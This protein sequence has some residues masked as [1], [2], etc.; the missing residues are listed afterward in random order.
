[1]RRWRRHRALAAAALTGAALLLNGCAQSVDPIE[2]LGE[3]AAQRVR[4]PA[5][6]RDQAY[7][8]WGLRTPLAPAP[9]PPARV[10]LRRR[11]PRRRGASLPPVVDRVPTPDKVV[12]LIYDDTAEKAPRFVDMVRELR[13]PVTAF[14]ADSAFRPRVVWHDTPTYTRGP[15]HL[16]PGDIIE[17]PPEEPTALRVLHKVQSRGLTVARLEDYI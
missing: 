16:R 9:N 6:A 17:L 1:M 7:R 2:R 12:F 4:Q 8:H 15:H 14:R 10:P 5:P 11:A 13:L 3:K